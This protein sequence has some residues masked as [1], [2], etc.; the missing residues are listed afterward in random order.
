MLNDYRRHQ[1]V[2]DF[3]AGTGS[4]RQKRER[5]RTNYLETFS[6]WRTLEEWAKSHHDLE[7]RELANRA[8]DHQDVEAQ[9]QLKLEYDWFLRNME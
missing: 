8:F 7:L 3:F 9:T 1:M 2:F 5:I 6:G 4:L